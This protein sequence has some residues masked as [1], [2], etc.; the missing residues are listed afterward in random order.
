MSQ[1]ALAPAVISVT[2]A[3]GVTPVTPV[4]GVTGVLCV[5]CDGDVQV[6]RRVTLRDPEL[7]SIS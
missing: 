2:D 5:W 1:S 4:T 7:D 3:A 6:A